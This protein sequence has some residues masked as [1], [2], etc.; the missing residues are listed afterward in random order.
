[1][2]QFKF[3]IFLFAILI[4]FSC[5]RLVTQNDFMSVNSYDV[6]KSESTVNDLL[7]NTD[8]QELRLYNQSII[9]YSK[10]FANQFSKNTL[11]LESI[12]DEFGIRKTI[13]YSKIMSSSGRKSTSDNILIDLEG[14]EYEA[15]VRFYNL[16]ECDSSLDVIVCIGTE[17]LPQTEDDYNDKI[18]GWVVTTDSELLPVII[19]EEFANETK[20][21]LFII[22]NG[23]DSE[24]INDT[25]TVSVTV[26]EKSSPATQYDLNITGER[27]EHRYEGSGKS[28][29]NVSWI[30]DK[31]GFGGGP[32]GYTFENIKD[33]KKNQINTNLTYGFDFYYLDIYGSGQWVFGNEPLILVGVTYEHDWYASKK[34]ISIP[35]DGTNSYT[36]EYRASGS[37]DYYQK[38]LYELG[39]AGGYSW[40][41]FD[42]RCT[43]KEGYLDIDSSVI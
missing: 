17:I 13:E 11:N 1:M 18:L 2:Q 22:V 39:T 28:E 24:T 15:G 3:Y 30:I 9:D 41:G 4:S 33:I 5:E 14:I 42:V 27:L 19:S 10:D 8:N 29:F 21:P 40:G 37:N 6:I 12:T 25:K 20:N 7:L 34:S 31:D 26:I 36:I 32:M 43:D 23:V 35:Y 16:E 38:F